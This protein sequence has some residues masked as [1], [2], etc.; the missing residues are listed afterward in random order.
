MA[1]P[2]QCDYVQAKVLRIDFQINNGHQR[3][4]PPLIL[5]FDLPVREMHD[6]N[7]AGSLFF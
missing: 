7:V 5:W 1:H 4:A 6:S 3:F 2:M